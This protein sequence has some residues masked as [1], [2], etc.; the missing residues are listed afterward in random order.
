MTAPATGVP[1]GRYG[2]EP[3]PTGRR[4]R[5]VALWVVGL[6]GVAVTLW[7]GLGAARTPVHWQD[8]GFTLNGAES[9]EVVFEVSRLDA[10]D[11]I[12]CRLQALNAQYAQVGARTVTLAPSDQ[13]VHR[14]SAV[15]ATSEAAVT[16]IVDRCWV[17]TTR[18]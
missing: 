3:T 10:S 12:E 5:V 1:P 18:S 17:A 7:I 15:V 11:A 2:R 14:L 16:G 8:V 9:V 4:R 6:V 13:K